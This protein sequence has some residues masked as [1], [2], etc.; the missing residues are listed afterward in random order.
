MRPL[1]YTQISL[2][3]SCPLSYKLQYVDGL[4]PSEKWY[5]SFGTT[6][7]VC[8]EYFFRAKL[9]RFPSLDEL[10][11][12]YESNW[13]SEG[14]ASKEDEDAHKE[15]GKGILRDFWQV[16]SA[17]FRVPLTVERRFHVEVEGVK[18]VGVID[19][20]D[21]LGSGGLSIVDYKS[22]QQLFSREYVESDLQ[23]T[24]YQ[25]AAEKT[26]GLPV[27]RLTLYHLRSNTPCSCGPR[28][29]HQLDA[30]KK[31]VLEVAEGIA[32]EEF[33]ATEHEYCPCD[34]PEHCPYYKHQYMKPEA[35]PSGRGD[36]I[37][38]ED[39]VEL[40]ASIQ[41]QS[42]EIGVRIE[43]LRQAI[44]TFCESQGLKR[45]S[46]RDHAVTYGLV[47]RSDYKADEVRSALEPAGL[48]EAVTSLD[49]AK[50]NQLLKS[51]KIPSDLK[52]R[53]LSLRE[54]VSHSHRLW[55]RRLGEEK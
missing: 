4:K 17:S 43:E 14:W 1:S 31:I 13:Q 26:W 50:L 34:F 29:P 52:S 32:K 24:L 11:Q 22:G 3:R 27:E 42:R 44:V 41:E 49:T 40:Y 19:R 6:L 36:E 2:Y 25:I 21:K 33:P 28:M 45:V 20:I 18:L 12:F 15:Y 51:D 53:L 47:E 37:S 54:V 7:H 46:G 38:L 10:L 16:H 30:A 39:M 8:A 9:P 55:V 23:L 48:W 5:F 35:L